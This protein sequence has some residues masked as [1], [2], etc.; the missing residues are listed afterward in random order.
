MKKNIIVILYCVALILISE[1]PTMLKPF[2]VHPT[3]NIMIIGYQMGIIVA[4]SLLFKWKIT[5]WV[6]YITLIPAIIFDLSDLIYTGKYLYLMFL[7][8]H[9]L[10]LLFFIY[11]KSI[12]EYL[13]KEVVI[14][15]SLE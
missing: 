4:I 13:Q 6:L 1:L 11:S 5:K 15:S 8:L 7:F 14:R 10:L 2:L 9:L 3:G 12:K